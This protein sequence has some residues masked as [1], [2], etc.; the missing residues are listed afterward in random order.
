M[1]TIYGIRCVAN[2]MIYVGCTAGRPS[3]RWREHRC[4]LKSGRHTSSSMVADFSKYGNE[5][6]VLEVLETLPDAAPVSEKRD[7]ELSWMRR[8]DAE[9]K[10]Y[11]CKIVS[12]EIKPD[13]AKRGIEASRLVVGKRWSPEANLKRRLAQL[14]KP[15]NHGHK[16]SETK[17]R[18]KLLA[19]DE[20]VRS[21]SK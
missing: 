12:F 9:G 14:G 5:R 13:D 1:V 16:I 3:K 17:R 11:N 2:G 4:L 21:A 20:I 10:L 7:A 8:F 18:K 6:F 15:K 19:S